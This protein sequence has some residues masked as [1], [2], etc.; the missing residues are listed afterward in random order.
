M[1]IP[2]V[3]RVKYLDKE[4]IESLGF[5][6]VTDRA[7]SENNGHLFVLKNPKDDCNIKLRFWYNSRRI[8]IQ[9]NIGIVFDGIIKNKSELRILLK[10]LEL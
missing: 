6:V 1:S 5:N 4:D 8:N 10:Q 7:M 2:N 9:D 3:I